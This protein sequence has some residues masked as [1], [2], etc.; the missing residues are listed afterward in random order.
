MTCIT[1]GIYVETAN[2]VE[3][4]FDTSIQK[5]QVDENSE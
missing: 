4:R 5:L 2:Y 3:I 1:T